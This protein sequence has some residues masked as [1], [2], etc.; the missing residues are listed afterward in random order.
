MTQH[1]LGKEIEM[2]EAE[3]PNCG[4]L[5]DTASPFDEDAE[6]KPGDAS[7]CIMCG[8][9][10]VFDDNLVLRNPTDEEIYKYAGDE[11][12][13]LAMTALHHVRKHERD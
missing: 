6:P 7:I 13:V 8:H 12:I 3:C 5:N 9:L 11:R 10:S 2:P 4:A 1:F